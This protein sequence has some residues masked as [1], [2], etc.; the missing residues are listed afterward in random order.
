MNAAYDPVEAAK[1]R[2]QF[3]KNGTQD[4]EAIASAPEFPVDILPAAM[5][6]FVE[7]AAAAV[8][9]PVEMIAVPML[10]MAA[11]VIGN[12][13]YLHLKASW[14]EYPTLFFVVV[15]GPGRAKSPALK[16]ARTPLNMLQR[17]AKRQYDTER[18]YYEDEL[19]AHRAKPSKE[20]G[21]APIPPKMRDYFTTDVTMEALAGI[22]ER[23]PGVLISGDE[24]TGWIDRMNQYRKGGDREQYMSIW[25]AEPIKVDR[26]SAGS[27]YVDTP[28]VCVVGGI[29][30]DVVPRLHNEANVR[31][32]FVERILPFVPALTP[33]VWNRNSVS[34]RA[35][36]DIAA[37]FRAIDA[38]P[39]VKDEE[40]GPPGMGIAMNREA[41]A[42]WAQWSDENNAKAAEISGIVGGFYTKLEAHVARFALVLHVLSNPDNPGIMVNADEMRAAIELGEWFRSQM[43]VFVPML[44]TG[45]QTD[46]RGVGLWPRIVRILRKIECSNQDAEGW[47]TK[48]EIL[49]G[50]GNVKT[51]E[52]TKKLDTHIDLKEVEHRRVSTATKPSDEYR[53]IADL[54]RP[55]NAKKHHE[56]SNNSNIRIIRPEDVPWA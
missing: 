50:L 15:A 33:K 42:V 56:E 26:K 23:C 21:T 5:R 41:E 45:A 30:P 54:R 6:D 2:A 14:R 36:A 48:G 8:P 7:Q 43:G 39:R 25:A 44:G 13:A 22:L 34:D 27:I 53:L 11:S 38:L 35:S 19:A 55:Q 4:E 32:G 1:I 40:I 51:E 31:D 9:V 16:L 10:G 12:R 3:S 28:V 47:A 37:L 49:R 29:Q 18:L 17:D 20:R 52:L 24:I 46:G